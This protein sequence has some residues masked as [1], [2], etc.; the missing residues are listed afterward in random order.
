MAPEVRAKE[1]PSQLSVGEETS[2]ILGIIN[3]EQA[4]FSYRV[5]IRIDGVIAD[6]VGLISPEANEK[7]EQE[8]TFA[9]DKPGDKQKVE[10]LLYKQGQTEA[11]E[12]LYLLVNAAN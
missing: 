7:R 1:Y 5:E 6:T 8:I 3:R 12:S 2:L 9:P 10:F 4:S 11:I